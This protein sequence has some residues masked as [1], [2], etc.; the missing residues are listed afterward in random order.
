MRIEELWQALEADAIT[1]G[2]TAWLTRRATPLP[3]W[4]LLVGFDPVNCSRALLLAISRNDL[5]PPCDWPDCHGLDLQTLSLGNDTY[6]AVRLRDSACADVFSTLAEDLALGISLAVHGC[7]ALAT[8]FGRL[9]RWQQFLLVARTGLA[10]EQERALWGE[11]HVALM[12]LLPVL[13]PAGL[14]AAWKGP[15]AAHQD[16]QFPEGAI[17]VKTTA[18]KQ[19]QSIRITSERQLDG[20][21]VNTLILHVVIIDERDVGSSESTPGLSLPALIKRLRGALAN[22][23]V[24]LA[25]FEDRLLEAGYLNTHAQRYE[26]YRRTVRRELSFHV[27]SD[28]PRLTE[29]KLPEGIGDVSYALSLSACSPF[30]IETAA[31]IATFNPK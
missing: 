20:T 28:F 6:F 4:P 1:T 15:T 24:A 27:R 2:G 31:A 5:P 3:G 17:E 16:F 25:A 13:G 8:I 19:P 7:E 26:G 30:S 12:H 14:V 9:R 23:P 21:G 10:L 29:H 11:L 18:A 22:E